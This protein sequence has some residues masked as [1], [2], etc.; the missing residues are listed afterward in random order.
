MLIGYARVSTSDQNLDLQ[1]DA[2]QAAGC[3]RLFTDTASGAKA[4]RPGLAEALK[5]CRTGDTL[6]VWKLDRLGRSLP[7]LVESVR[8][9]LAQGVGFNSLQENLDTTTSGGKLIFHIFASLAEFERDLIK[10]RTNAGLTAARA[11]GR[12]GGR[13]RGVVNEKKRQA[14]LSL[15]KDTTRTVKEI[16]EILG[17]SRNT[18]YKYTR[19][20]CHAYAGD[21][22]I[23]N[24]KIAAP[25][26]K[27]TTSVENPPTA[28]PQMMKVQ[29]WMQVENNSKFVRGKGK[30]R[31]EIEQ[32]VLSRYGMERVGNGGAEYVLTIQYMT[33]EELDRIIYEEIWGEA[34]RIADMH[35]CFTEGDTVSLENPDR[36]W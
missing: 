32:H 13:P 1:K 8:D 34:Q 26:R 21:A 4:E 22:T 35:N 18:Y 14:A 36:S 29:L 33:D 25:K 31:D 30:A 23:I 7:H 24:S 11:R 19:A 9:L 10:E 15:K 5:E 28:Q 20:D 17:I 6:V 27:S 2:L 16:C 12:K 3:E